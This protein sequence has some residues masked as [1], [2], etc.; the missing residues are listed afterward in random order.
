MRDENYGKLLEKGT[1]RRRV[2]VEGFGGARLGEGGGDGD[3]PGLEGAPLGEEGGDA[4]GISVEV[5]DARR[6]KS[7][8]G[9]GEEGRHF[10]ILTMEVG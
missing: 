4:V 10:K 5:R 1:E 6:T 2:A 7:G 3:G 8:S 9:R